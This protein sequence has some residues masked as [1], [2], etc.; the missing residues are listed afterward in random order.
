MILN[1]KVKEEQLN[2]SVIHRSLKNKRP[3]NAWKKKQK[4]IINE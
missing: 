3:Q 2:S 4:R 1:K